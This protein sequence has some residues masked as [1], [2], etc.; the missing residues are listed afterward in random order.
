MS[1]I[2][3]G[4]SAISSIA[5]AGPQ[6][7]TGNTGSTGNTGTTGPQGP[8]GPTGFSGD[9]L[10]GI[11]YT[12]ESI[13]FVFQDLNK[14][15]QGLTG[16]RYGTLEV[17]G[18]VGDLTQ[19]PDITINSIGERQSIVSGSVGLT[20]IFK[21]LVVSGAASITGDTDSTNTINIYG[22]EAA[23]FI[24]VT[25][26]IL[27]IPPN[28]GGSAQGLDFSEYTQTGLSGSSDILKVNVSTLLQHLTDNSNLSN[29]TLTDTGF[30]YPENST[31]LTASKT[32]LS[33]YD[34]TSKILPTL[35]AG[36]SAD[37]SIEY[38]N[39]LPYDNLSA[40]TDTYADTARFGSCCFCT[41]PEA[42]LFTSQCN[43]YVSET[44][45]S[46]IGGS[47]SFT[48]CSERIADSDCSAG[49][50]CCTNNSKSIT[51]KTIC[52]QYGGTFFPG[53]QDNIDDIVCPDPCE[54]G[55]CC[56]NGVCYE[57]S[58]VECSL[59]GGNFFPGET[60]AEFNC[61]LEDLYR[62]ACCLYNT[63]ANGFGGAECSPNETPVSCNEKGGI[64]QGNGT[65]CEETDCCSQSEPPDLGCKCCE[66]TVNGN[67]EKYS[68]P[69][70]TDC[71]L[72]GSRLTEEF[73]VSFV[74]N[75]VETNGE[76]RYY[77]AD[78]TTELSC[79]P[80]DL[81][82][83]NFFSE[84]FS[85]YGCRQFGCTSPEALN[86]CEFATNNNFSCQFIEG[87]PVSCNV[88]SSRW[89]PGEA[90]GCIFEEC[91]KPCPTKKGQFE[92]SCPC[93]GY[94]GCTD[95][96]CSFTTGRKYLTISYYS[97]YV[98]GGPP[99]HVS[100]FCGVDGSTPDEWNEEE[101]GPFEPCTNKPDV[102][103]TAPDGSFLV[104]VYNPSGD[105]ACPERSSTASCVNPDSDDYQE[106]SVNTVNG[107][108]SPH[109][110]GFP[111]CLCGTE[112]TDLITESACTHC[113]REATANMEV[114][115]CGGVNNDLCV[116][117]DGHICSGNGRPTGIEVAQTAE[118]CC[119]DGSGRHN[120]CFGTSPYTDRSLPGVDPQNLEETTS[121]PR[122]GPK[123]GS[124]YKEFN[125]YLSPS[126]EKS[127]CSVNVNPTSY[128]DVGS[129]YSGGI[130]LGVVGEPN[131]Y[132][133]LFA[134]GQN[135]YC[136][137][138][139][140]SEGCD[141][142]STQD[143]NTAITFFINSGF[144]Y[145]GE[146]NGPCACD[147]V[148]P[149]KYVPSNYD[150]SR[151]GFLPPDFSKTK[152]DI[153]HTPY[154]YNLY[155]L[156]IDRQ[157]A[158]KDSHKTL[159][160]YYEISNKKTRFFSE[161]IGGNS[162]QSSDSILSRKWA[163]VVAPEDLY[164][165]RS[166]SDI[167]NRKMS[168][169]MRQAAYTRDSDDIVEDGIFMGT[170]FLD[171]L[172]GTRMFDKSSYD[173]NPWFIE[174]EEG[175]DEDA[176][177]RWVHSKLNLWDTDVDIEKLKSDETYFKQEFEKIWEK[178]NQQNSA[179]RL[180][181]EWNAENK[182]GYN[183][184]Y[185]PSVI[186]LMYIY[187]NLNAI[188]AGLLQNGFEPM[189]QDNYWSSTTGSKSVAKNSRRCVANQFKPTDYKDNTLE[190]TNT[191]LAPHA[192]RA[193]VQNFRTGLI[194]SEFRADTVASV[195]PVRRVPLHTTNNT[196]ELKG[197]LAR[198]SEGNNGDCYD[199][200]TCST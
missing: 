96:D 136:L 74:F 85:N 22:T 197:H 18:P 200:L 155:E 6:G 143:K 191:D 117:N 13:T 49:G 80:V 83:L 37:S 36:A 30:H 149:Y 101:F 166:L 112:Q 156:P 15:I 78:G 47:F 167:A 181:S 76:C 122:I 61:C 69:F 123:Y 110:D 132:G 81:N 1:P 44:Y 108:S 60:C 183:D 139:G 65:V 53:Q 88:Q 20:G 27:F 109:V 173:W 179:M 17:T 3:Y 52:D 114:L 111:N 127:R 124:G 45:C 152:P 64:F 35:N 91:R 159:S 151:A 118:C 57:F 34:R 133:S 46:E 79:P 58:P 188:N 42:G 158:T 39:F 121:D 147:N 171:G 164:L 32:H 192:H 137:V 16:F 178:D 196:R 93:G 98:C 97:C 24:G 157:S 100:E 11:T 86:Y 33:F 71:A 38:I 2:V 54:I 104:T 129:N 138:H 95:G 75:G 194:T 140:Y 193:F 7:A 23:S 184:W 43:D 154:L 5:A 172:L 169:G 92:D 168:W 185:I 126:Q 189:A 8:T 102:F 107:V 162:S 62:G 26:Q 131:D 55:A 103:V 160:K 150:N 10:V 48:Q 19:I 175:I 59:A 199:C 14:E 119:A 29:P 73:S 161:T 99:P 84:Y 186:E 180:V 25:G 70:N 170:P 63:S 4:S 135:P 148:M 105:P 144:N 128:L 50:V 174:N 12:N 187:G 77:G 141:F 40:S 67:L 68:V 66:F 113:V 31:G 90:C 195:R 125:E 130:L 146:N 89:G 82:V 142:C 198:F 106:N 182:F 94:N 87:A 163:L 116:A 72:L 134:K 176:Y 190:D 165:D 21:T 56:V 9:R 115:S 28:S 145:I 177:N 51:T 153:P 120:I 41:V